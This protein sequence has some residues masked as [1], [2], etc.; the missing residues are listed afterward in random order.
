MKTMDRDNNQRVGSL[1]KL[2]RFSFKDEAMWMMILSV[3]PAVIGVLILL[4]VWFLR[5]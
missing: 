1:M 3:G 5:R 4:T 2:L